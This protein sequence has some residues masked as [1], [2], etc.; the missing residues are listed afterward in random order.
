VRVTK[1]DLIYASP[2]EARIRNQAYCDRKEYLGLYR[3][4]KAAD[5]WASRTQKSNRVVRILKKIKMP[6]AFYK[7][8]NDITTLKLAQSVQRLSGR[9]SRAA[10]SF[11]GLTSGRMVASV[12]HTIKSRFNALVNSLADAVEGEAKEPTDAHNDCCLSLT[13]L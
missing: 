4:V 1:F 6:R 5:G 9:F 3:K 2:E 8:V 11:I 12:E 13:H 10:E 7:V